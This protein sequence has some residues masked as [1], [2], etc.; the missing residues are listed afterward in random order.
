MITVNIHEAKTQLSRYVDQAA[1]GE[2]IIIARAGK[3]VARLTALQAPRQ[4]RPLGLGKDRF[5]Y[6]ED[7][8]GYAQAEL[9]SLFY[10]KS[11]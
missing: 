6:P 5:S 8:D 11:E 1:A 9:E 10:G 4:P 7:F 2:E 3:P